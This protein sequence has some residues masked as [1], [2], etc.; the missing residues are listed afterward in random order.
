[1]KFPSMQFEDIA[2]LLR[3]AADKIERGET[4]TM[5][6]SKNK[7]LEGPVVVELLR[8]L[9]NGQTL[10]EVLMNRRPRERPPAESYATVERARKRLGTLTAAYTEIAAKRN[11][12]NKPKLHG[13]VV[14]EVTAGAIKKEYQRARVLL[15]DTLD[16]E[17]QTRATIEERKRIHESQRGWS[18]SERLKGQ[19]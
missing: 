9:A 11:K 8:G 3:D 7:Y 1:M 13:N 2:H 16:R 6:D 12:A 5:P 4:L 10:G 15:K 18:L 19:K 14:T 17:A